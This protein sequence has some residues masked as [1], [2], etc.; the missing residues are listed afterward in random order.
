MQRRWKLGRKGYRIQLC[1]EA[2]LPAQLDPCQVASGC[3]RYARVSLHAQSLNRGN[4]T[5]LFNCSRKLSPSRFFLPAALIDAGPAAPPKLAEV[6]FEGFETTY[7]HG[8]RELGERL[9]L[10]ERLES[11]SFLTSSSSSSMKLSAD[12]LVG[13]GLAAVADGG[14]GGRDGGGFAAARERCSSNGLYFSSPP[15][16]TKPFVGPRFLP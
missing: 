4:G 1:F 6:T 8:E 5:R 16:L 9:V 15:A 7:S 3:S 10:A 14:G 2:V 12:G 13:F 11:R